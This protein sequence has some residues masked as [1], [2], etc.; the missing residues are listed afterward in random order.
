MAALRICDN[1]NSQTIAI[2]A[3]FHGQEHEVELTYLEAER[4][5]HLL[6]EWASHAHRTEHRS[7]IEAENV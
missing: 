2:M 5:M 1:P 7:P 4:L 3:V 6:R